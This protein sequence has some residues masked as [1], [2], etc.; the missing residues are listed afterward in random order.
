[1]PCHHC[2]H[3]SSDLHALADQGHEQDP[4]AHPSTEPRPTPRQSGRNAGAP[5]HNNGPPV[6]QA[7]HHTAHVL[8]RRSQP[9]GDRV[10][11][12]RGSTSRLVA[13]PGTRPTRSREDRRGRAD[14]PGQKRITRGAGAPVG[15]DYSY[16]LRL[17][18]VSK[19]DGAP[20]TCA[21]P[22]TRLRVPAAEAA[23][24]AQALRRRVAGRTRASLG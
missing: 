9:G 11:R 6:G 5:A 21:D 7:A 8:P 19:E 16:V 14:R 12:R 23:G 4:P 20:D 22:H 10:K 17:C 13:Q 18:P 1:M 24:P 3:A 15:W 2:V